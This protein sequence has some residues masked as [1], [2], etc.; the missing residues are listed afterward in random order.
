MSPWSSLYITPDSDTSQIT[1]IYNRDTTEFKYIVPISKLKYDVKTSYSFSDTLISIYTKTQILSIDSTKISLYKDTLPLLTKT[2]QVNENCIQLY[3]ST[4]TKPTHIYIEKSAIT[5]VFNKTNKGDTTAIK[6]NEVKSLLSVTYNVSDSTHYIIRVLANNKPKATHYTNSS[7]T[8]TYQN[9][10]SGEYKIQ[11]IKDLNNNGIWDTGNLFTNKEPES[12]Q[13]S[14]TFE[15]R[16][17][18]DKSLIINV[19]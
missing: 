14:K 18:W 7:K 1:F 16:E 17:N 11:I 2:K 19:L 13:F 6:I 4:T 3:T 12:I 9:L 10:R 15:I 5:D 8:I